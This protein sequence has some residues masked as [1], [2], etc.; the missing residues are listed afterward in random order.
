MAHGPT[1]P[2]SFGKPS[3]DIE[4]VIGGAQAALESIQGPQ[5]LPMPVVTVQIEEPPNSI[6]DWFSISGDRVGPAASWWQETTM[7]PPITVPLLLIAAAGG[8]LYF[9]D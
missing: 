1:G 3:F 6:L 8:V 2:T 5:G 4:S 9:R 7:T